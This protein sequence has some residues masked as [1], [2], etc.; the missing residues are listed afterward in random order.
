MMKGLKSNLIGIIEAIKKECSLKSIK[1]WLINFW[2]ENRFSL[3][4]FVLFVSLFY[5]IDCDLSWLENTKLFEISRNLF[6]KI[7]CNSKLNWWIV[8]ASVALAGYIIYRIL[9]DRDI[10]LWKGLLT[11]A[12]MIILYHS[13]QQFDFVSLKIKD[14]NLV[15]YNQLLFWFLAVLCI[16]YCAK[17]INTWKKR[18]NAN[19]HISPDNPGFIT[20]IVDIDQSVDENFNSYSKTL[21]KRLLNTDLSKKSF[22]VGITGGWGSGKSTFLKTLK[23]G[24]NGFKDK[25]EIVEFNPWM[26]QSPDQVIADFFNALREQLSSRHS[27]LSRPIKEYA[28]VLNAVA[29][30]T[31]FESFTMIG[32]LWPNDKSLQKKKDHLSRQLQKMEKPVVVF[33]DDLDRLESREIFE[34]LRLVRNTGD[35]CN[36]IYIVAYDKEYLVSALNNKSE[37]FNC[38][39]Y[40]EKIFPV[41]LH[42][43]K[44]DSSYLSSVFLQC[45]NMQR[46]KCSKDS[47]FFDILDKFISNQ[48]LDYGLDDSLFD[49]D[50]LIPKILFNYRRV[51]NFSRRFILLIDLYMEKGLLDKI[52][53]RDLMGIELLEIHDKSIFER[54]SRDPD[55]LLT[56]L[57]D[58]YVFLEENQEAIKVFSSKTPE[59]DLGVTERILKLLFGKESIDN[60]TVPLTSI[61]DKSNY[62]TYF[63]FRLP[64]EILTE[65]EF[66]K[67]FEA[68]TDIKKLV[69]SWTKNKYHKSIITRFDNSRYFIDI[70]ED[71]E[72]QKIYLK[73]TLT[74]FEDEYEWFHYE[75]SDFCKLLEKERFTDTVIDDLRN[76]LFAW[77]EQ[78]TDYEKKSRLLYALYRN[79]GK[80]QQND[81]EYLIDNDEIEELLRKNM[82]SFFQSNA[83]L[84][85]KG[86]LLMDINNLSSILERCCVCKKYNEETETETWENVAFD[87]MSNHFTEMEKKY[88]REELNEAVDEMIKKRIASSRISDSDNITSDNEKLAKYRETIL[89]HCF[90]SDYEKKLEEL[91][92]KCSLKADEGQVNAHAD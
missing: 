53:I 40:L 59:K 3:I 39:D 77:F 73:G 12:L 38:S 23:D 70:K 42:L 13:R 74:V 75:S 1:S 45:F 14:T 54:L 29:S 49:F 57:A 50:D 88:T 80:N 6:F 47:N 31:P 37:L 19:K 82:S 9:R 76:T 69:L 20:D 81:K 85:I 26:C 84:D 67:I 35:L 92:D 11:A 68:G 72:K 78:M 32:S 30:S 8:L 2:K 5:A 33:I 56:E 61:R 24:E 34:V 62:N 87:I 55:S 52:N 60:N 16:L 89:C 4:A 86:L 63:L 41:E 46:A 71:A 83:D 17:V 58:Q 10:R 43:P 18:H 22:A 15:D 51:R 21:V 66:K 36:I 27:R 64:K 25:A 28:H 90:G 48:L 79:Q 65:D 7:G 91:I 44:I